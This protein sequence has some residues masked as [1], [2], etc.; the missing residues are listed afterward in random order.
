M[1]NIN[2]QGVE[3]FVFILAIKTLFFSTFFTYVNCSLSS[4][5]L[6]IINEW[7][8]DTVPFLISTETS[9]TFNHFNPNFTAIK[10]NQ[11]QSRETS[12]S[13]V[14][15][16]RKSIRRKYKRLQKPNQINAITVKS[17]VKTQNNSSLIQRH[18][19]NTTN[20]NKNG[21]LNFHASPI[22]SV[23]LETSSSFQNEIRNMENLLKHGYPKWFHPNKYRHA[24]LEEKDSGAMNSFN[25]I[26]LNATEYNAEAL[27]PKSYIFQKNNALKMLKSDSITPRNQYDSTGMKP[28][29]KSGHTL[30]KKA[31][32]DI[33]KSTNQSSKHVY[34]QLT[35]PNNN[36][37]HFHYYYAQPPDQ[38]K[39][40][41]IPEKYHKSHQVLINKHPSPVHNGSPAPS[42][43]AGLVIVQLHS[44]GR[45]S[46]PLRLSPEVSTQQSLTKTEALTHSNP[47]N[48]T[49]QHQHHANNHPHL[50]KHQLIRIPHPLLVIF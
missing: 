40:Q 1:F 8:N 39:S 9:Q 18:E 19:R 36:L 30:F 48:L 24:H 23:G 38:E 46:S 44:N 20:S 22:L 11:L 4:H 27:R 10:Q 49:H 41:T 34:K 50:S 47:G 3:R 28:M 6:K 35:P 32:S 21:H 45:L 17:K 43:I 33:Q 12:R 31:S 7:Q 14:P 5:R 29:S 15:K 16:I 2:F 13:S 26:K 42:E 25:I 37:T